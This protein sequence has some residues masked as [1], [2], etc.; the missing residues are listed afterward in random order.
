MFLGN[1]G[2]IIFNQNDMIGLKTASNTVY[3]FTS[4]DYDAILKVMEHSPLE[5]AIQT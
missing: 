2:L 5:L 3:S 1:F 4:A